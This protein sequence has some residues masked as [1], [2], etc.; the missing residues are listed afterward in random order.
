VSSARSP[1]LG[2]VAGQQQALMQRTGE[3]ERAVA[4]I[5][6]ALEGIG[7]RLSA[8]DQGV[9][10]ELARPREP[11]GVDPAAL[12]A[13]VGENQRLAGEIQRLR[14]EM[15]KLAQARDSARQS[16][17]LVQAIAALRA[18]ISDGRG[19]GVELGAVR[20]LAGDDPRIA[21][22]LARVEAATAAGAPTQAQ[23]RE[24]FSAVAT[25]AVLEWRRFD[26]ESSW[27]RP[28]ADRLTALVAVRRVGDVAGDDVEA[29]LARAEHR[30]AQGDLAGAIAGAE[31]IQGPAAPII[32]PWLAQARARLA[33]DGALDALS[34]SAAGG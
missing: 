24:R 32:A 3:L 6:S 12:A 11:A 13:A 30:L 15:T 28:I 10:Q 4:A 18:A 27:W 2:P 19:H 14:E 34:R 23:L 22:A 33:V 26:D 17:Q 1:G 8:L 7:T 16:E 31:S 5:G 25:A 21:P 9:R 20:A 29:V